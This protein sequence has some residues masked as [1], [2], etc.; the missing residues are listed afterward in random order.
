[1]EGRTV[2][3][4][5]LL[6]V[7]PPLEHLI[8]TPR[9]ESV[10]R[11][12]REEPVLLPNITTER[13]LPVDVELVAPRMRGR[14][15]SESAL[16]EE[17]GEFRSGVLREV[18][19]RVLVEESGGGEDIEGGL[20]RLGVTLL[21]LEDSLVNG[22]NGGVVL[23]G[24]VDRERVAE[25][26]VRVEEVLAPRG[27]GDPFGRR[28]DGPHQLSHR[29][30]SLLNLRTRP[31]IP[32]VVRLP[33]HLNRTNDAFLEVLR[34]LLHDD[35]ALLKGVLLVNLLLKL[36]SNERVGVPRV[37][38]RANAHRGILEHGDGASEV[39]NHLR[40]RL[41]LLRDGGGELARVLLDVADVGLE[42]S[43][44]LLKVLDDG[45]FDGL[46]E[47]GVGVG[48]EASALALLRREDVRKSREKRRNK[49]TY[50]A[51]EDVLHSSL[52][53]ELVA[54]TLWIRRSERSIRDLVEGRERK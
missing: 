42:L 24:V 41:T 4:A 39:G 53:K 30:P 45:T 32:L 50:D 9:P 31:R 40:R 51:V 13:L 27:E 12:A 23:A 35:D 10:T 26:R 5:Q 49:K 18:R 21:A 52:T 29:R 34:V 33:R 3:L 19:R 8:V 25:R 17:E 1:M 16:G 11:V 14:R 2:D 48:D 36:T 47:V 6:A 20:V 37:F 22:E 44:K 28:R 54:L 15:R 43:T 46:G 7:V 38:L